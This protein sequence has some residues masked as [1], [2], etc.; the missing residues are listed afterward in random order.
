M[1]H[2]TFSTNGNTAGANITFTGSGNS[3]FTGTGATTDLF[4]LTLSKSSRVQVVEINVSNF[5]VRGASTAANGASFALLTSA[6]G[7]GT[8]KFSGT[9]SFDGTLYAAGY[10]IPSQ[11][12]LWLNNPNFTV[13]GQNGSPTV[14]V[15]F[16]I[17]AGTF[18]I[19]T[20]QETQWALVLA[21][22]LL[23]KVVQ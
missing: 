23:L 7:T 3:S 17:T 16:R 4:S 14:T 11:W 8:L 15:L 12:D 2:S 9:N 13:N 21:V 22:L 20:H 18:N 6:V 1:V 10:T 19:G 5:T